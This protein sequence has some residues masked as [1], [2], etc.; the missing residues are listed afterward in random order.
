LEATVSSME[1]TGNLGAVTDAWVV[2]ERVDGDEVKTL[3]RVLFNRPPD[4]P[5][6]PG[7]DPLGP[8]YDPLLPQRRR[9]KRLLTAHDDPTSLLAL[10]GYN[11]F[12][13]IAFCYARR[14]LDAVGLYDESL[15]V[16]GDWDFNVRF[17][18][19]Y[20]IDFVPR[21]LAHYHHRRDATGP[22]VNTIVD[23]H[24]DVRRRLLNRYLRADL[25]A[26]R[27]GTG[28]LANLEHQWRDERDLSH[29]WYEDQAGTMW[30]LERDL[31]S[32]F[33]SVHVGLRHVDA[34]I[35]DV[36]NR[37]ERLEQAVAAR[38]RRS[39]PARA[40]GRAKRWA[41]GAVRPADAVPGAGNGTGG[42]TG[43][44]AGGQER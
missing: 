38:D 29:A 6:E 18:A 30:Q 10:L 19:H 21:P 13:P 33:D 11:Q 39:L 42:S 37:V 28:S 1:R 44:R 9:A 14:A 2:F 8:V 5:D 27:V 25:A 3:G 12:P 24:D 20:D 36:S 32:L 41:R 43:G 35:V 26:G 16:L 15:P 23:G 40:A 34:R 4:E 22:M 7:T 31:R 17:V